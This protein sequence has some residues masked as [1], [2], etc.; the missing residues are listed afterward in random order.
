VIRIT[1]TSVFVQ[2]Q[3]RALRFYT[4]ALG[5][6]KKID[7]ELPGGKDR[8]LTVV[9]AADPDG[10]QLL[11]EPAGHPASQAYQKALHES[12]IAATSF[13]VD[14]LRKEHERLT[15]AGVVFR[16]GPTEAGTTLVAMLDDTCGNL[17]QL[18][19]IVS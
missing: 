12:G 13:E 5:F 3:E 19:Q 16:M 9:S 1:L 4:E 17:I 15:A 6:L 11:L 8:W 10:V 14:D 18:H 7:M 2:D